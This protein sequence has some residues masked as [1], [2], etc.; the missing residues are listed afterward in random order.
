MR[1]LVILTAAVASVVFVAPPALAE[2]KSFTATLSG[3]EE[4]PGP[5]DPDGSGTAK[6]VIDESTNQLCYELTW[7]HIEDPTAAHIHDGRQGQD[8]PVV[9]NFDLPKNGPKACISVDAAELSDIA[10][11]PGGHYVNLH[12]GPFPKGAIRG[13]LMPN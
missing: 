10:R 7:S 9:V 5:G 12:N 4:V 6:V 13:Q 2:K 1:A 3:A 8:G 11:D